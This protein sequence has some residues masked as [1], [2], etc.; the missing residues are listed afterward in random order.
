[1][2]LFNMDTL[3]QI[4]IP[5]FSCSSIW[6]LSRT[7]AWSRWGFIL[8]LMGQPFWFY[9]V[10]Q[11]GSWGIGITSSWYQYSLM[12]GFYNYWIIPYRVKHEA[13]KNSSGKDQ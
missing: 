6:L 3:V 8:G 9:L 4:G 2:I 1:M 11:T 12:Q 10:W 5:L 13:I 7:E